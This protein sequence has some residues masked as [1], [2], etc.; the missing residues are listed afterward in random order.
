[1]CWGVVRGR[2]RILQNPYFALTRKCT[3]GQQDHLVRIFILIAYFLQVTAVCHYSIHKDSAPVYNFSIRYLSSLFLVNKTNRCTEFQFL[4][5][6]KNLHVSGSLSAHHQE[7]FCRTTALVQFMQLVDQWAERLPET[8]RV[9]ITSK[10]WNSVHL[11]VLFTRN[12]S[13][14]TF[15]QS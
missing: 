12:L 1:M 10:N 15:I 14:C 2:G 6:I 8:C 3:F 4:L 5:V 7:L 11:L 9:I 13:R